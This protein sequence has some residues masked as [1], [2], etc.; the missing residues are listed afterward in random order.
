MERVQTNYSLVL[1]YGMLFKPARLVCEVVLCENVFN[2]LRNELR[3]FLIF[4][5]ILWLPQLEQKNK[6]SEQWA[7]FG[8][9]NLSKYGHTISFA[10][11]I[12]TVEFLFRKGDDGN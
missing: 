9:Q 3:R 7:N 11:K 1:W 10:S 12:Q 5:K 4:E 2:Q 6:I 8:R